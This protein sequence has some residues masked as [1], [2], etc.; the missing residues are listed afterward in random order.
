VTFAT[1]ERRRNVALGLLG[2]FA[3]GFVIRAVAVALFRFPVP[4]DTAYYV[5]VS[6]NVLA[7]RG[8]VTDGLFSF[9]TPP[10]G[11]P[12]PAFE[13]WL[14]LPT[15]LALIP[16]RLLSDPFAGAQIVSLLVG[17]VIP[18]VTAV[19][20]GE[21][22]LE[23]GLPT[24]RRRSLTWGSGI[25]AAVLGPLVTYSALPDSTSLFTLLA[26][27]S[28]L[29]MVHLVRRPPAAL[30]DRRLVA[31][32]I[33]FGLAELTRNEAIYLGLV[34]LILVASFDT[35]ARR[36]FVALV[37]AIVAA[38]VFA[39]WAIR[40]LWTFGTPF[41]GQALANAFFVRNSDVYAYRDLPSLG[42]YLA[43][44]PAAIAIEHVDGLVSNFFD[45]LILPSMP[46]GLLG[47]AALVLMPRV[48]ASRALFP[49]V[50]AS[51]LIF[52][53][54]S[55]IF[56]V[57]TKWGTYLH[58]S[59]T[60][61]VL[62]IVAGL[63]ATDAVIVRIGRVRG[64]H[65][66]VAWL[67]AA[68]AIGVTVPFLVLSLAGLGSLTTQVSR[69]YSTLDRVTTEMGRPLSADGPILTDH[70]IWLAYATAGSAIALPDESATSIAN[71]VA[72][73]GVRYVLVTAQSDGSLP[74]RLA[75]PDAALLCLEPIALID[76]TTGSV[77]AELA[78][79]RLLSIGCH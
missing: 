44:G 45:V 11:L 25:V 8:M 26:L 2:L 53:I 60:A 10:L 6:R 43:Q 36:P 34:W 71:L 39:P 40:D 49:L 4:E 28:C 38:I 23:L 27:L 55:L 51:G 29:V 33:L 24:G 18:L 22:A 54:A 76:Q 12:R 37:P 3:L 19:F 56:P 9:L 1:G 47:L 14:P 13:I 69:V 65:N 48:R 75:G 62:L 21:V 5:E 50:L 68:F 63:A 78:H 61:Y 31:L 52:A 64:W 70:P 15:L 67:G 32:G 59:G 42:R 7:G 79:Q 46:I 35:R 66:P 58:S 57:A 73:F 77:P 74:A 72:R 16:A 41:P 30:L 17:S 20:A